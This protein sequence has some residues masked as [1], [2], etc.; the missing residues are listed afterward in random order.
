MKRYIDMKERLGILGKISYAFG[1]VYGGGA[2]VI[3]SF[4]LLDFLTRVEGLSGVWAGVIMFVGKAW[5]AV[6]DPLMGML[7]DKTKSKHGKRRFYFLIGALPVFISWVMLWYSFGITGEAAKIVYYMITYM[8]FS[9]AFT[10]VMVPYN[11]ILANMTSDYNKRSAFTAMRL[12]FSAGAAIL[13]A[14]LP[15][16][17]TGSFQS[18]KTGYLI[19][20]VIFGAVFA[21]SWLATF[22]GTWENN[23]IT[24]Q[25]GFSYKEWISV[26]KNKSFRIYALTFIFSQMAIDITMPIAVIFLPVVLQKGS[27]QTTALGSLMVVQLIFIIIFSRFAQRFSKKLPGIIAA[28]VWIAASVAFFT[29]SPQTPDMLI[30]SFCAL[31]G[32]GAAGCNLVS[33]SILPDISDVDELMTGKRREGLYSGV[34]TF[35]RKLSGGVM[36]GVT[37]IMLDIFHYSEEAVTAGNIEPLTVTGI[38]I[39]FCAVPV[40]FLFAMLLAL[41]K[42]RLGKKEFSVMHEVIAAY[43]KDGANAQLSGEQEAVYRQIAGTDTNNVF[44]IDN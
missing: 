30:I 19:M 7:S 25:A 36:V 11:A 20:A 9:T 23:N 15:N 2:F 40:L 6:T 42:Y 22:F 1:D 18:I 3:V 5:D 32:V 39:L 35:L 41:R 31:I 37:G 27:L 14:T 17:I 26:F 34:S 24:S 33:W 8:L 21:L 44:G 4:L 28:P 16:M 43:R 29:F 12:S 38:K 10:I 13:C